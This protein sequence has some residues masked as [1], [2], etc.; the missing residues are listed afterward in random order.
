[1]TKRM[2]PHEQ[3]MQ[4]LRDLLEIVES[5]IDRISHIED[6]S[7]SEI[8]SQENTDTVEYD[9]LDDSK[10]HDDSDDFN[11]KD[12]KMKREKI[13]QNVRVHSHNITPHPPGRGIQK[14]Y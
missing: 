13:R 1:M 5:D 2:S 7:N 14:C 11:G 10:N 3:E 4:R 6:D 9:E 12:G 8:Y